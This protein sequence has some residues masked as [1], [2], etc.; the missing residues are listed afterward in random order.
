MTHHRAKP[1][2]IDQARMN[3]LRR[4]T[5]QISHMAARVQYSLAYINNWFIWLD[6]K[7]ILHANFVL[8]DKDVYYRHKSPPRI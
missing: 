2:L 6:I 1:G 5:A 7:I 4:E 3:G 8:V